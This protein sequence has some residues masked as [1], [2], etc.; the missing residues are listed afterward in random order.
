MDDRGRRRHRADKKWAIQNQ[1][2]PST[3]SMYVLRIKPIFELIQEFPFILIESCIVGKYNPNVAKQQYGSSRDNH[4][5][6]RL[7]Q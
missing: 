2:R 3:L 1:D 4:L 7:S 5:D 6:K